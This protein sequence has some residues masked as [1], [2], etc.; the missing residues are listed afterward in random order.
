MKRVII[1]S[2]KLM[3]FKSLASCFLCCVLLYGTQLEAQ[4]VVNSNRMEKA[5]M[6]YPKEVQLTKD[7]QGHM[8]NESQCFSK[9]D[10][11]IVYDTRNMTT[12]IPAN[13]EIAMV[14][15]STRKI[16]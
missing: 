11:W 5:T 7:D 4:Q 12:T 13:P 10:S 2:G 1:K 16:K 6:T 9:D 14:H 15:T 3:F 8:I